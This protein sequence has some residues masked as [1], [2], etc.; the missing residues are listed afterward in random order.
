MKLVHSEDVGRTWSAQQVVSSGGDNFFGTIGADRSQRK[1]VLAY[2]TSRPTR[3]WHRQDVEL[4][5]I[6][7]ATT[8]I[9]HPTAITF[10]SPFR[11]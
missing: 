6:D 8:R 5:V 7:A 9:L 2:Y 4:V 1:V 3:L 11:L 10:R